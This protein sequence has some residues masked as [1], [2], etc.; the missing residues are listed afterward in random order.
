MEPENKIVSSQEKLVEDFKVLGKDVQE[1]VKA[2]ASVVGE[3]AA[4]AR[5]K[6]RDSLKVV[7]D[8]LARVS[9]LAKDQGQVAFTATDGYVRDNPWTAVG[10]ASGIGFLLGLGFAS[11]T[12]ARSSDD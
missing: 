4:D 11:A 3:R 6:A 9:A 8:K 7:Q 1:L 10:I 12:F 2:T 5:V